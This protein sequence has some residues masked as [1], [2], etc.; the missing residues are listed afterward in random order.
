MPLDTYRKLCTEAYDLSKPEAHQNA[1]AF[2]LARFA[3]ASEPVLEPMCGTGRY[4]IPFLERG[5]DI[6]GVDASPHMLQMCRDNALRRGV[7]PT[8]F[9]QLLE[10]MSLSRRYGYVMIPHGS[11]GFFT[12]RKVAQST[13]ARLHDHMLP[14]GRLVLDVET[15]RASPKSPGSW[16]GRWRTRPDGAQVVWSG[17]AAPYDAPEG[18]ERSLTRYELFVDGRLVDTELEEYTVRHYEPDDF[19]Q[20]LESA[21]FIDVQATRPYGDEELGEEDAEIVFECTRP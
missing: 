11:F 12:D 20:L 2:Y 7:T 6:D 5:I 21:G 14:G 18:I 1:L 16:T 9:E 10:E 13:L 15:P 4:L 3:D 17:F 19:Q 8:L